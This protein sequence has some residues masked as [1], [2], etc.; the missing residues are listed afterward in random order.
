MTEIGRLASIIQAEGHISACIGDALLCF[1]LSCSCRLRRKLKYRCLLAFTE[2][3]QENHLPVRKLQR[4]MVSERLVLVDLSEDRRRVTESYR[5]PTEQA[6]FRNCYLARKREFG[7]GKNANRHFRILRRRE[8]P[9][10]S[11][12]VARGE[13]VADLGRTGQY[14]LQ[15]V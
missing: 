2:F 1:C 8:A 12:E 15:A 6:A 3:R 11:T 7:A 4:I 13:F 10:A 9:R 5:R 14:A